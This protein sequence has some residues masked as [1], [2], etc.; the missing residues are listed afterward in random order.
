MEQVRL[1]TLTPRGWPSPA[2]AVGNFDGVHRGH[3]AL[4]ATALR[5]ARES[6]GT[7]VV[8]TFDPHPSQVLAPERAPRALLTLDQKAELLGQLGADKLAVLPFTL[9]LSR[10]RPEDFAR[11]VLQQTLGARVVVVGAG[12][13]FGHKRAGDVALLEGMGGELGFR[14]HAFPPMLHEGAPISSTRIR[15]G[16]SRGDV[17]SA[18]ELLGRPFFVDGDVVSGDGRG[19]TIGV[20]TANLNPINEMLPCSGVYACRCEAR[21]VSQGA[22]V[23]IGTRPTFGGRTTTIE[24]HLLDFAGDL[25]GARLRVS[26]L[27]RLREERA[28][29]GAEALIAQIRQDIETARQVLA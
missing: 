8:L 19:R 17:E 3:Q 24:A 26:F 1:E 27:Q 25:Y 14:V 5:D 29:S 18:S 7:A 12:F 11:L 22:V 20:P 28:F 21:G 16:L 2:V 6:S 9:E 15:E 4:L 10:E 23:N 13:R